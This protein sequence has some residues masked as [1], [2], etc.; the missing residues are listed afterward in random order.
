MTIKMGD[1]KAGM[2]IFNQGFK[3]L[4]VRIRKEFR[5]KG[6]A[7][8]LCPSCGGIGISNGPA[9]WDSGKQAFQ[10]C[11]CR[12]IFQKETNCTYYQAKATADKCNDSIRG[13]TYAGSQ[14]ADYGGIDYLDAM[15]EAPTCGAC[16][17]CGELCKK[18]KQAFYCCRPE[19]NCHPVNREDAACSKFSMN[20][21]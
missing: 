4:V 11:T 16:S 3:F 20:N 19:N 9:V 5:G 17:S 15:I 7:K 14:F 10:C 8:P 18:G 13:T 21:A 2:T 6:D 1:L 12:A